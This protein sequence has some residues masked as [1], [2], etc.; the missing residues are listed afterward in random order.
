MVGSRT[1]ARRARPLPF[2]TGREL[3][4]HGV[5]R[6]GVEVGTGVVMQVV[7]VR[8]W[9]GVWERM[10]SK[11][12]HDRVC[13]VRNVIHDNV[14]NSSLAFLATALTW[15][16]G[17]RQSDGVGRIAV[18]PEPTVTLILG[19]TGGLQRS[20]DR[21]TNMVNHLI[22]ACMINRSTMFWEIENVG[23]CR[24]ALPSAAVLWGAGEV[25]KGGQILC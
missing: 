6:R 1:R 4:A 19:S 8:G 15:L 12:Y 16:K 21:D 11:L 17:E 13:S 5:V 7:L 18:I 25:S 20:C 2:A 3:L 22:H 24:E 9:V 10:R 14:H 23:E